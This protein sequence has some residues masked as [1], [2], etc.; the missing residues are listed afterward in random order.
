VKFYLETDDDFYK[1][2]SELYRRE[3]EAEQ[4]RTYA[5]RK[6]TVRLIGARPIRLQKSVSTDQE[7][8]TEA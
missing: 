5:S 1:W 4:K 3:R 2:L 8:D 7:I 6:Q